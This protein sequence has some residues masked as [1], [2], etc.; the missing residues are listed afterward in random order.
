LNGCEN[1]LIEWLF[2]CALAEDG[3]VA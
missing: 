2:G 1:L 3:A